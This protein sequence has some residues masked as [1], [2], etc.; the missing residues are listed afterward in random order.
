MGEMSRKPY[1]CAECGYKREIETNHYGETYSYGNYNVCPVCPPYKRPNAWKFDGVVPEGGRVP[2][3]W[4]RMKL[5]DVLQKEV[6]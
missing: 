4:R 2:E 6:K 3:P 5:G 1:C